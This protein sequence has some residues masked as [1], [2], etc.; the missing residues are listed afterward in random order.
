MGVGARRLPLWV[1]SEAYSL[2]RGLPAKSKTRRV[3]LNRGDSFA[4]S[5]APTVSFVKSLLV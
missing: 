2:E 5:L 3:R 1:R 4:G